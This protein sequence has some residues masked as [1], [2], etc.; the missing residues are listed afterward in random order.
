MS[1]AA[2][3]QLSLPPNYRRHLRALVAQ[4]ATQVSV[5]TPDDLGGS[6]LVVWDEGRRAK[7]VDA[8]WNV[9]I[10]AGRD[11][12]GF[13]D[14]PI[15]QWIPGI[16]RRRDAW[17]ARKRMAVPATPLASPALSQTQR[18][19]LS[20]MTPADRPSTPNPDSGADFAKRPA[21][22]SDLDDAE[23]Y[24]AKLKELPGYLPYESSVWS[25]A[26][27]TH[28]EGQSLPNVLRKLG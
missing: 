9:A 5:S 3:K 7:W 4:A 28:V 15:S 13:M 19:K 27:W 1:K 12:K 21:S 24:K 25:A 8:V 26:D 10:G 22:P 17:K 18:M 2:L 16:Q 14:L 23:V 11:G 6:H 20:V